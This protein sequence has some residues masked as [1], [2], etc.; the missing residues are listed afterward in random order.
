MSKFKVGDKVRIKV[1]EDVRVT[2]ELKAM[3]GK[4][5]TIVFDDGSLSFP[6][7]IKDDGGCRWWD[8]SMFEKVNSNIYTKDFEKIEELVPG[9]VV[10]ITFTDGDVQKAVCDAADEFSL[11]TA[12]AVC[13]AKHL[14]G[15][16]KEYN[17]AIRAGMNKWNQ[18]KKEAEEEIIR[19]KI[20]EKKARKKEA[21]KKRRAEKRR[22][23]EIEM[24][25]EAYLR[26]MREMDKI[27]TAES[28]E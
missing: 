1:P 10:R 24:R 22:E 20:A 4:I 8:S 23:N 18:Q 6:Y 14:C 12:I 3:D 28:C 9:K 16:T 13:Y 26:A 15:G 5:V 11:E 2:D 19:E 25:K 27:K 7:K 17:K 21:Y